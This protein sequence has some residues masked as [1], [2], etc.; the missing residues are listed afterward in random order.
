[1]DDAAAQIR[2]DDYLIVNAS[3]NGNTTRQALERMPYEVQ[4]EG[5][6]VLLVQ[7]GMN[8]CNY[9]V[10]DQGLPR[11]SPPAF[12][13]N[14][15][16]I[17]QRGLHFGARRILLNTNHPTLRDREIMPHTNVTYES[18]NQRYN[19]LIREV[20]RN[21]GHAVILNDIERAFLRYTGGRKEMLAELVMEDGLH[22]SVTGHDIYFDEIKPKLVEALSET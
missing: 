16:E 5:V 20:A 1:L 21:A 11:V 9:W 3:V 2:R 14:L 15:A 4:A 18:S 22:L 13:A 6:F 7:F 8:D 17:I 12:A 10:S 19:E